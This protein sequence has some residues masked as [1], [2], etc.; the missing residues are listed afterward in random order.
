MPQK[1]GQHRAAVKRISGKRMPDGGEMNAELVPHG[2]AGPRFHEPPLSR[3]A[4][5]AKGRVGLPRPIAGHIARVN[6]R[7]HALLVF[8]VMGDGDPDLA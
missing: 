7:I 2:H 8:G 6:A 5:H 1:A 3:H 4:Q